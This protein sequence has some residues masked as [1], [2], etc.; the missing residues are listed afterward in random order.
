MRRLTEQQ[1]KNRETLNRWLGDINFDL[2]F[3]GFFIVGFALYLF[4]SIS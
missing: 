2:Y 3:V 1:K 4:F